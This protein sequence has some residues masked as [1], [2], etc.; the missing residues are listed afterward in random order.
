MLHT[1]T[2]LPLKRYLV[3]DGVFSCPS[4]HYTPRQLC[5]RHKTLPYPPAFCVGTRTR[6]RLINPMP[7]VSLQGFQFHPCAISV[8]FDLHNTLPLVISASP[9][10][11]SYFVSLFAAF[12]ISYPLP[13]TLCLSEPV[14]VEQLIHAVVMSH[15]IHI[16]G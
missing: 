1:I 10:P 12:N 14:P 2:H 3:T 4:W 11:A 9:Y 13:F 16:K 15:Q 8:R 5:R 6:S 7:H